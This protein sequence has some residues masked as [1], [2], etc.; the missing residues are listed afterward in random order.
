MTGE[1]NN[2]NDGETN[3][4]QLKSQYLVFWG[5]TLAIVAVYKGNLFSTIRYQI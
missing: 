4:C 2:V 1:N 3:V 5:S